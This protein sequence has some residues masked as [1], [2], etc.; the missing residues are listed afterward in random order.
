MG[1]SK[2]FR[3]AARNDPSVRSSKGGLRWDGD[4][5]IIFDPARQKFLKG[6]VSKIEAAKD[7]DPFYKIR[8]PTTG[9]HLDCYVPPDDP[10]RRVFLGTLDLFRLP[11]EINL[12]RMGGNMYLYIFGQ[13]DF[14]K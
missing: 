5:A 6:S 4:T 1:I 3:L 7:E 9:K 13:V 11:A 8:I 12:R 2:F 14:P 10:D